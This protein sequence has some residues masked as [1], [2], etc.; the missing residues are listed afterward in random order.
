MIQ[1]STVLYGMVALFAV[2]GFQ[3]GWTKEMIASTGIVL[4]L[5][6]IEQF[7]DVFLEP[8]TVGADPAQKFYFYSAIL[9]LITFFAYQTPDRFE[10][11]TRRRKHFREGGLQEGLLGGVLG[12]LNGY[13]V[14][15]SL[16]YYLRIFGYPLAPNVTSPLPGTISEVMQY[17]LPLDWLLDGNLLTLILVL[18][19]LF[20]I[21]VLI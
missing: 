6:T 17:N 14:V 18:L 10:K 2:V 9:L 3:R 21:V 15:G 4:A 19:F 11:Q 8:L 12:S 7:K 5:F 1:L 13:L 20:V 16:W